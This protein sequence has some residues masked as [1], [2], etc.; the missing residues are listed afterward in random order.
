MN[1]TEL[2]KSEVESSYKAA[3]KLMDKV[4]A[5]TLEW[6]PATGENWMTVG[7][8][9]KH[10]SDACGTPA[11]G[12]VTGDWGMPEGMK[13]EDLSPEQML[14]PAGKMPAIGSVDEAKR[15]LAEDKVLTL[16]M[17]DEAG[18]DALANRQV[19]SAFRSLSNGQDYLDYLLNISKSEDGD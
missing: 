2:L 12:F 5:D 19:A 11:K 18:E 17:I 7:Q 9:L 8:L 10:I 14:P 1:W 13:V 16:R 15:L 6:K 3:G 4:G